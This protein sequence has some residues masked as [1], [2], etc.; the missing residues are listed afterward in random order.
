MILS[1][2][3]TTVTAGDQEGNKNKLEVTEITSTSAQK[4]CWLNTTPSVAKYKQSSC[5]IWSKNT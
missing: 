5:C 3:T 4:V 1:I 2:I